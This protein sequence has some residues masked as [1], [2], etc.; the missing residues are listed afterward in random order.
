MGK[1]RSKE[2]EFVERQSDA[3]NAKKAL[4]ERFRAKVAD[5]AAPERLQ[6]RAAE[7]AERISAPLF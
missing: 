7:A 2:P 3:L 6:A 4:L 1:G 5:P